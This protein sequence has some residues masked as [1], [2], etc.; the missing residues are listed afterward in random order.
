MI[1]WKQWKRIMTKVRNLIR[2]GV[3]KSNAWTWANTRNGYWHIAGNFIL[4]T[5]ITTDLLREAGYL[6]LS[7]Y[8]QKV[9]VKT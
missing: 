1:I 5:T 3:K 4:Q 7:D 9:S 6:F 8:Y 2:L